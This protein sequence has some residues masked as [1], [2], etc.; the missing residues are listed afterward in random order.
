MRLRTACQS[1]GA[2]AYPDVGAEFVDHA[3]GLAQA[4]GHLAGDL[5]VV[6]GVLQCELSLQADHRQADDLI[7]RRRDL[8]HLHL[9]FGTDEEDLGLGIHFL[10][11]VRDRDGREDVPARAAA[12]DDY[13]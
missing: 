3:S 7:A 11:L 13:A 5:Q 10:E 4:G 6:A 12:A 2:L 1:R 8:L 9:A